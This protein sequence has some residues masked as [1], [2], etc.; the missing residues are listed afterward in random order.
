MPL[1][2]RSRV[3][4]L[5]SAHGLPES[6]I[7]RGDR[8]LD[9]IRTTV[10]AV[11]A[12]LALGARARLCFQSRFGRR[13]WLGPETAEALAAVQSL[14]AAGHAVDFSYTADKK[15]SSFVVVV[16]KLA[17]VFIYEGCLS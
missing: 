2:E 4:V 5:F 13:R 10:A 7:R 6:Y 15:H 14:R 17:A 9:E 1:E 11:A 16:E 12:R 8:Y 3:P